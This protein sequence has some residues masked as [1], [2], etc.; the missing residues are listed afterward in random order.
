MI[1]K[2]NQFGE[3]SRRNLVK[4][5]GTTAAASAIFS[6]IGCNG[7]SSG[8]DVTNTDVTDDTLNNNGFDQASSDVDGAAWAAGGT[9]ALTT[10]FPPANPFKESLGSVCAATRSA[11]L[12]P[13]YFSPDDYRLDITDGQKGI[14]M[15]LC[16]KVVD[17]NCRPLANVDVDAWHCNS[18]GYYS[19][20]TEG[21]SDASSFRLNA[22]SGG[23][24]QAIESRWFRGVQKTDANGFVYFKSCFPGWYAG[25]T[26]HIHVKTVSN[27]VQSLVTQLGYNTELAREIYLNHKDYT[28]IAQDTTNAQ[29]RFLDASDEANYVFYITKNE[30]NSMTAYKTIQL[31]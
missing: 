9:A 20:N 25:R 23:N 4:A 13:C 21:S 8:T 7:A 29:D 10:A 15:I 6:L 19:G 27:G 1:M 16:L 31:A 3:I 5:V 17:S 11:I 22:C 14:P 28:G 12:G 2:K 24:E 30:D 26:P 18:E